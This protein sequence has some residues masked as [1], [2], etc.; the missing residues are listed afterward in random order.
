MAGADVSHRGGE[1]GFARVTA[2]DRVVIPDYSG[3]MMFN[4]LGN[5]AADPRA[6][7]LVVDFENGG[8]L[9]LTGRAEIVWDGPALSTFPGA[10]RLVELTIEEVVEMRP[11]LEMRPGFSPFPVP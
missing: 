7:L 6:G 9:Q 5:L 11:G 3:N 4:T 8:T 1:R 10:E 2:A